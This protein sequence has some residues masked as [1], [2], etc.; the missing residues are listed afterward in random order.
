MPSPFDSFITGYG[1]P[2]TLVAPDG[3][4]ALTAM[5]AVHLLVSN[6]KQLPLL[7]T[8]RGNVTQ[9]FFASGPPIPL[10]PG[11][12][13]AVDTS[14][15][16]RTGAGA[17]ASTSPAPVSGY[18]IAKVST[19]TT[20]PVFGFAPP[21]EVLLLPIPLTL[22]VKRQQDSTLPA[23]LNAYDEAMTW[24]SAGR[25]VPL[26]ASVAPMTTFT[27]RAGLSNDNNP[28]TNDVAGRTPA[29]IR[30]LY[31][32]LGAGVRL[33]DTLVMP[34]GQ[35]GTVQQVNDLDAEGVPWAY[36]LLVDATAGG[37]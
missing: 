2:A 9:G 8:N 28:L 21:I 18:I 24:D 23:T 36:Q 35:E 1:A 22:T 15:T 27:V 32:P 14:P 12:V 16:A 29:G 4:T 31:V 13:V 19:V 30:T 6:A 7:G 3:M 17:R 34:D 10:T 20:G 33:G 25:P 11:L 37:L 5:G 26:P